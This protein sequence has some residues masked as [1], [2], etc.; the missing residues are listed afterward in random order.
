MYEFETSQDNEYLEKI[1]D[2]A[3]MN[4]KERPNF[5]EE[6]HFNIYR[7]TFKY[8]CEFDPKESDNLQSQC[9]TKQ[10]NKPK[11]LLVLE[12][13]S[14]TPFHLN[15]KIPIELTIDEQ[16]VKLI[17]DHR[18]KTILVK[19][20]NNLLYISEIRSLGICD[21]IPSMMLILEPQT[22]IP[23]NLLILVPDYPEYWTEYELTDIS[24]FR[25]FDYLK[26]RDEMQKSDH[27]SRVSSLLPSYRISRSDFNAKMQVNQ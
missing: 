6:N 27:F 3:K 13:L 7:N 15:A 11:T 23:N 18:K 12:M 22:I 17:T 10:S 9:I 16:S 26:V 24:E 25:D 8:Y 4:F 5:S 19:H 14:D 21:R 2:F 1:I 20:C